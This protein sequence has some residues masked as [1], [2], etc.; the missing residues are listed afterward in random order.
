MQVF[1]KKY[2]ENEIHIPGL[3]VVSGMLVWL[4]DSQTTYFENCEFE[5]GVVVHNVNMLN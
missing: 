1:G 2:L 5:M 3:I 4:L